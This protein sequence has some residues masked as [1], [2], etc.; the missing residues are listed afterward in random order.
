ME[1][2]AQEQT[3]DISQGVPLPAYNKPM[4]GPHSKQ[5]QSQ[6]ARQKAFAE[7]KQRQANATPDCIPGSG[8]PGSQPIES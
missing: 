3:P 6:H 5:R 2:P 4:G 7:K 1:D 8:E